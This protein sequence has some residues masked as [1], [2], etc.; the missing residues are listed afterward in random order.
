MSLWDTSAAQDVGELDPLPHAP[1]HCGSG[2]R[3]VLRRFFRKYRGLGGGR[4]G[5]SISASPDKAAASSATAATF[6][7]TAVAAEGHLRAEAQQLCVSVRLLSGSLGAFDYERL[8][9]ERKRKEAVGCAAAHEAA[10]A[11]ASASE[12]AAA[13]AAA[14]KAASL[15]VGRETEGSIRWARPMG[16]WAREPYGT[17]QLTA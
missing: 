14:V 3:G 9:L 1:Q 11:G 12:I 7:A 15:T 10:E 8:A 6:P 13:A 4:S 16:W 5:T 17:Q 2:H